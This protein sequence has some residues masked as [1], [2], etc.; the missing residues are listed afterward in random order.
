MIFKN[1]QREAD[2]LKK[3]FE[4]SWNSIPNKWLYNNPRPE[5]KDSKY[6]CFDG[7]DNDHNGLF[8]KDDP[9]CKN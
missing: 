7:V 9:A 2:F 6:S 8:D 4:K 5:G 3:E 1:A